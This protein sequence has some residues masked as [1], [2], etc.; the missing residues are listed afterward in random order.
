MKLV[1]IFLDGVGLAP[2]SASNP[3]AQTPMI[4]L[5]KKIGRELFI[6][7]ATLRE[8][9]RIF[10]PI[11]ASLGVSGDGQSG[12]GQ[13]SIYTSQNGA[14]MFGRH[15]GPH[16][17]STLRAS[18]RENNIFRRLKTLGKTSCYAN[19]YSARYVKTTIDLRQTGKIRHSVLFEAAIEE[20]ILIRGAKDLQREKA[21]SGDITN[22]WWV[23]T[24]GN[25]QEAKDIKIISPQRAAQHL[26][27]LT[28]DYDAVFYEFFL[29]DLA[30]HQR[31]NVEKKDII[32][33]LDMFLSAAIETLNEE[34]VLLLTS[35]HGNFEDDSNDRHTRNPVPLLAIGRHADDFLSVS[36]IDQI[37]NSVLDYMSKF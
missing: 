9:N 28:S 24:I 30:G 13:F 14:A 15:Y 29:T 22:N 12:T 33:L 2:R 7:D 16:L 17:P 37:T 31:I 1:F 26:V 20:D 25:T 4:E 11:D 5:R 18:L 19:A 6:E 32:E 21:V 10:I 8:N 35:D 34:T 27:N 23:K 36:S 3:F